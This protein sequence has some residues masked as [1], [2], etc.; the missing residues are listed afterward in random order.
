MTRLMLNWLNSSCLSVRVVLVRRVPA[1]RESLN[2]TYSVSRRERSGVLPIVRPVALAGLGRL[3]R[4]EA[5]V[6][7][8]LFGDVRKEIAC[9]ESSLPKRAIEETLQETA[10]Q[11]EGVHSCWLPRW[12]AL[13][14]DCMNRAMEARMIEKD[15]FP[16]DLDRYPCPY[17]LTLCSIRDSCRPMTEWRRL[18][19]PVAKQDA[20]P[21]C[22]LHFPMSGALITPGSSRSPSSVCAALGPWRSALPLNDWKALFP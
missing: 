21:I 15:A 20:P 9:G 4:S 2:Q 12:K 16:L 7:E 5:E 10:K 3:T 11:E 18:L 6:L 8:A 22:A 13:T 17:W 14:L 19:G 1:S